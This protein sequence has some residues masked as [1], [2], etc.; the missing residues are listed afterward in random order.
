[1]SQKRKLED[2]DNKEVGKKKHKIA[3]TTEIIDL[4]DEDDDRVPLS[5]S[6]SSSTEVKQQATLVGI[7]NQQVSMI[8]NMLNATTTTNNEKNVLLS[9]LVGDD[10]K[11]V[12]NRHP[13]LVLYFS[14]EHDDEL[15]DYRQSEYDDNDELTSRI[16]KLALLSICPKDFKFCDS[17]PKLKLSWYYDK[18]D[19]DLAQAD[20]G[21]ADELGCHIIGDKSM[22]MYVFH[23]VNI[24]LLLDVYEKNKNRDKWPKNFQIDMET[25]DIEYVE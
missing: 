4:S 6:T 20:L 24:D 19:R 10:S 7:L 16:L 17:D 8:G 13:L 11:N 18:R 5:S 15:Q 1:M 2:D 3:T 21:E 22:Y 12:E 23:D 9:K 25:R 14:D